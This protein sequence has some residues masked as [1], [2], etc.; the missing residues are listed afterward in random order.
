MIDLHC[1]ILP[2]IDDGA[3]SFEEAVAMV[4]FAGEQGCTAMVA[5]PHQRH[6]RW[7]NGDR[8]HLTDL[9]SR[10]QKEAGRSP[11]LLAGG[12][13]RVDSDWLS[14]AETWPGGGFLPIAD[15]QYL[16]IEFSR[17]GTGPEPEH[18]VHELVIGG[19]RPILAHPE[20]LPWLAG[21]IPRLEK[22]VHL[23]AR[24]Q[25]TAM[26]LTGE[27]GRRPKESARQL[28]DTSLAHFIASDCHGLERRPPGLLRAYDLVAD[29]WNPEV[30]TLLT[31]TNPTRVVNNQL[32]P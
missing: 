12:E 6:P 7:W 21:D 32:I 23:G 5:T 28:I 15:T 3:E 24:L 17:S 30:A 27:F 2:G 11:T 4:R 22:L 9:R 1:H 31:T 16:L 18:I 29:R 26:S 14:E 8:Q 13:I 10:L 20:L 25:I 19:W